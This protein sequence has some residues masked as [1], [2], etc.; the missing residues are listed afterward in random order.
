MARQLAFSQPISQNRAAPQHGMSPMLDFAQA[1][2]TMVDSQ[3][4]TFDVTD[5]A[6]LTA[7]GE[8]QRER[9][10]PSGRETL[11]YSDQAISLSDRHASEQRVMLA[12]MVL[13]RLIQALELK[14]DAKVLDV[15]AGLGYASAVL[16]RLGASVTALESEPALFER[17]RSN[18]AGESDAIQVK[19]GPLLQGSPQDGPFDAILVNGGLVGRPVDLLSQLKEG[20]RLAC[21]SR[22]D[23][24]GKAVVYIRSGDAFG[25]RALFDATAPSLAE[26]RSAPAFVF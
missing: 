23:G 13:A 24:A 2:R 22:S 3:L 19:S 8:I 11:A 21:L 5:R 1:R 9:F 18:L 15:A 12:P 4:R 6:I 25:V 17:L 7:M 20:G 14:P 26:T 10:M 16:A